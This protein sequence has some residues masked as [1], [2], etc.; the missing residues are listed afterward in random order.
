MASETEIID[1]LSKT[2]QALCKEL[3]RAYGVIARLNNQ[4]RECRKTVDSF[5]HKEPEL[6]LMNEQ[7]CP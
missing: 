2:N 1:M 6:S 7:S 4:I 5:N 3:D